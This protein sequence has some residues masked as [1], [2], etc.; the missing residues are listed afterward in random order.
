MKWMKNH[1]QQVKLF[2]QNEPYPMKI[3]FKVTALIA[4]LCWMISC[5][6]NPVTGKKELMLFTEEREIAIGKETDQQIRQHYGLYPDEEMTAYVQE[7]GMT[8]VP[9]THRPQLRY[10]FSI[11]DTPVANAFAVPGGYI[12]ITRGLMA[13]MNSEAELAAV[14]AHELGHVNARHS[15][16]KMSQLMLI[17]GGLV[18]GSALSE[19]VADLSGLATIGIQL[20][21]LKFSRNDERQAD[22]LGVLYSRA[23]KYN[24]AEMV[25]FFQTLKG[26]G[27]LSD[28][29]SLPGFLS[30]HPMYSERIENTQDMLLSSDYNLTVKEVPYL[31]KIQGL[32]FGPDPRQGYVENGAFYHPKMQ[33]FFRFPEQWTL[34]NTPTQVTM[35]PQDEKAAV[36]LQA[37]ESSIRL[38]EYADKKT[39]SLKNWDL[40]DQGNL[41]IHGLSSLQRTYRIYQEEAQ[42]LNAQ[43]TFIRKNPY[44]YSFTAVS[45]VEDFN[46][47]ASRFQ[48]IALSFSHL[49]DPKYLR[50]SPKRIE[51]VKASGKDT[52]ETIFNR[53]GMDQELW[54][55]FTIMNGM[56]SGQTPGKG[57]LIKVLR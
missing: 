11:L 10:H 1:H 32:V 51:V 8:M 35:V 38:Q 25:D 46:A 22:Q 36:I 43:V 41:T 28:G 13:M 48:S 23:G 6:T 30:T 57:R 37:V 14:L 47:Y 9:H 29:Q 21:F 42:D 20:L 26:V 50:R 52:L 54:P 55:K 53:A 15:M 19:T 33:F 31:K 4:L 27:D 7:V 45:T 17:Q 56:K 12:Y 18:V 5:V 49:S 24:P 2:I 40:L 39:A 3:I 34:Q 44:I 16:R